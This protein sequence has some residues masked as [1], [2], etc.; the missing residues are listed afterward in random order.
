MRRPDGSTD[1]SAWN[2]FGAEIQGRPVVCQQQSG[3]LEVFAV[4]PDGLLGHIW[5]QPDPQGAVSWSPWD[6]FGIEIRS[7]PAVCLTKRGG[8]ELFAI[9]SDDRL[10]HIWQHIHPNGERAW[11]HWDS[12]GIPVTGDPAVAQD[13]DGQLAVLARGE[14]GRL[15]I[16]RQWESDVEVGWGPWGDLGPTMSPEPV[17]VCQWRP[18]RVAEAASTTIGAVPLSPPAPAEERRPRPS[19]LSADFCV[20]GA[21]PAGITLSRA[22]LAAGA[23]VVLVD[24]GD[25]HEDAAAQ[26]L[27]HGDA[28]GPI[29]KGSLKYLRNGRRRQVQ[30]SAVVWGGWCMPFREV[31]LAVRDW[32][33]LSGWP[34]TADELAP[35]ERQA[36][37]SFSFERFP[38]PQPDG[39]LLRVM[40]QYPRDLLLFRRQLMDLAAH[41]GFTLE[42]GST[43]LELGRRG[44][45]TESVRLARFADGEARVDA[46]TF[47]LAAGGVENARILLHNRM[48]ESDMLGRCFMDHPHVLAGTVHLPDADALRSCLEGVQKLDVLALTDSAQRDERLLNAT[49]QLMPLPGPADRPDGGVDCELFVRS[50]QAPNPESRVVLGERPDRF[51]CPQPELS[52]QLLEQDWT[53][54]VRTAEFVALILEKRYG[55]SAQVTIRPEEPWP[56]HPADPTEARHPTWGNHHMG[57]TRM[58]PD[59]AEGVVDRDCR[60][61][62]LDNVYVAGSSVFPTGGAANPTFTIV[63]LTHRLGDHLVGSGCRSVGQQEVGG[64]P[65]HLGP[66]GS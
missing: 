17:G 8:L 33:P 54:V 34:V 29:I 38:A 27:N 12:F 32:V 20:I 28:E 11:S 50:E 7:R 13:A 6:S 1:W 25:W 10:G 62:G 52:W 3:L 39:P 9:G 37:Q 60:V 21:G 15:G 46:G 47:V 44:D 59:A 41:P 58:S 61:H 40:Y 43:A 42:L 64:Q 31:D 56:G 18:S 55:A 65:A 30:G 49:V 19:S 2:S 66:V 16:I 35:F 45:R 48:A 4:G 51:G 24:S 36:A 26:T 53:T 63:A 14:G 5:Q 22:L 57:T 23:S